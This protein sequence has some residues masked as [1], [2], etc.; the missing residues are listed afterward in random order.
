MKKR[1]GLWLLL[2]AWMMLCVGL[3][4]LARGE[5]EEFLTAGEMLDSEEVQAFIDLRGDQV[6]TVFAA[7]GRRRIQSSAEWLDVEEDGIN[8]RYA[9]QGDGD[10][11]DV[12][13]YGGYL[14]AL[15]W[16]ELAPPTDPNRGMAVY[17]LPSVDGENTLTVSLDYDPE[18][19][20]FTAAKR[21]EA[22]FAEGG[23]KPRVSALPTPQGL[24]EPV[25]FMGEGIPASCRQAGRLDIADGKIAYPS[26]DSETTV[27]VGELGGDWRE[28]FRELDAD[29]WMLGFL[30]RQEDV[31]CL[32]AQG[33]DGSPAALQ[34]LFLDGETRLI[35]GG[36]GEG[37][38]YGGPLLELADGTLLFADQGGTLYTCQG[39]GTKL[40][41]IPGVRTHD[42][43]YHEGF[44][45]FANLLDQRVYENVYDQG[46]N[47][48]LDLSFP[49]LYRARLDGGGLTKL[50]EGGVRGLVSQGP[51]IVYQNLDDPYTPPLDEEMSAPSLLYGSLYCYNAATGEHRALGIESDDYIPTP[52]GLAVWYHDFSLEPYDIRRA[53]LVLHGYDGAPLYALDAGPGEYGGASCLF[54][55]NLCF[56]AYNWAYEWEEGQEQAIFTAT[57]LNGG[58]K[59]GEVPLSQGKDGAQIIPPLVSLKFPT[60]MS[61]SPTWEAEA[62]QPSYALGGEIA[63][64]GDRIAYVGQADE[65]PTLRVLKK[66]GNSYALEGLYTAETEISNVVLTGDT[67][68]YLT[69]PAR[70]Q[71]E[72][73]MY[74][75]EIGR[76]GESVYTMALGPSQRTR[77]PYAGPLLGLPD[78]RLLF[79]DNLGALYLCGLDG[80]ALQRVTQDVA[81]QFVYHKGQVYFENLSDMKECPR[82]YCY[83][84]G[85]SVALSFPNLY[86]VS[87][88]G[89]QPVRLTEDG[90]RGPVSWGDRIFYQDM[91]DPFVQPYGELPEEWLCGA[92]TRL[93]PGGE[94]VP[95]GQLSDRYVATQEG[96]AVWYELWGGQEGGEQT[97]Q[98]VFHD[99]DG[100]IRRL[101]DVGGELA[102]APFTVAGD[103][104]W[105]VMAPED[106]QP[107]G[108]R[109]LRVPLDGSAAETI[110]PSL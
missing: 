65:R 101:L 73:A 66:Q 11:R 108:E 96:L 39:D 80:S 35:Q 18:G 49:R 26:F 70:W 79:A 86:A 94:K 59:T 21:R 4:A 64:Q 106:G 67:V 92:L 69:G 46:S 109:L 17:T 45:Y 20:V 15:G 7:V 99:W 50:T 6:P 74:T 43:V 8:V 2:A 16:K 103:S 27:M 31:L 1:I 9:Y 10:S 34:S 82:V 95:L 68:A 47:Q 90:V 29:G 25:P 81:G 107:G 71:E 51:L 102:Y 42:F 63:V 61:L 104:L 30:L 36:E 88:D 84:L 37:E 41:P 56:Y 100:H 53:D 97:G 32:L 110:V 5:E 13:E 60:T 89:S 58:P 12:A 24:G 38:S 91:G 83:E 57:P 40:T 28:D 78:G 77:P 52:W 14:K 54:G 98:L 19:Y 85:E 72:G 33:D 23:W 62:T 48:Y 44:V 105:F 22:V 93:E 55:G 87:L 3:P 75:L 76:G